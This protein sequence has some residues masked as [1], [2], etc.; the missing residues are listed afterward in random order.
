MALSLILDAA[1]RELD[2][3]GFY[4]YFPTKKMAEVAQPADNT[5][6]KE[7]WRDHSTR[8]L[9]LRPRQYQPDF[10]DT[11]QQLNDGHGSAVI[12]LAQM[13]VYSGNL[14]NNKIF[15]SP[16]GNNS[17]PFIFHEPAGPTTFFP[18]AAN[19]FPGEAPGSPPSLTSVPVPYDTLPSVIEA[20][21]MF[22]STVYDVPTT[23]PTS[24][25]EPA[26]TSIGNT[27]DGKWLCHTAARLEAN[28]GL[29]L[30]WLHTDSRAGFPVTYIFAIGQFC[31]RIKGVEVEVFRDTSTH[32]DRSAWK[33]VLNAPLWSSRSDP[34][35]ATR[36]PWE[37][38]VRVG[39]AI[40]EGLNEAF[41][42]HYCSLLWLP[43]RRHQVLLRSNMGQEA[44]LTVRGTPQRLPDDSDWDITREDTLAIWVMTPAPGHLQV[45][46]LAYST[47]N[48]D[49]LSPTVRLDYSPSGSVA[50]GVVGDN[51]HSTTLSSTLSSP[52]SYTLTED[53]TDTCVTA[54][55]DDDQS[56]TYGVKLRLKSSDGRHTPFFYGLSLSAERTF[57]TRP[58]T[59]FTVGSVSSATYHL[60]SAELSCGLNPGEGRLTV[61]LTDASPYTLAPYYYRSTM[62]VQLKSGSTVI[63]TGWTEPT[64]VTPLKETGTPWQLTISAHDRWKQLTEVILQDVRDF[65]QFGHIDA[66]VAVMQQAGIDTTDIITPT[67]TPNV[68]SAMNTMLGLGEPTINQK[69][70]TVPEAWK[71]KDQETAAMFIKR[72]AELFSGWDVGFHLDGKPFYHPRDFYTTPTATF[73]TAHSSSSPY[74]RHVNFRPESPEANVIVVWTKKADNGQM[75]RS[76]EFVDWASIKNKNVVNYMGKRRPEAIEIGHGYSCRMLNWAARKIWDQTRRRHI[77]AEFEA[78]FVET[79]QVGHVVTIGSYGDY[80]L[81]N[82]NVEMT[83]GTMTTAHYTGEKLEKG[84]GLPA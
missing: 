29:Y 59:P 55:G 33:K 49:V 19:P 57:T 35:T 65:S 56:R 30:R 6:A 51:D 45:Q 75:M 16:L 77:V 74:C 69:T 14:T 1:L 47:A 78:D 71:P 52:P 66:V 11:E 21:S 5:S 2:E 64:E 25:S 9:M 13:Q 61:K 23:M 58:T 44:V 37:A 24:G 10:R 40:G 20:P 22:R 53:D 12:R 43:Y 36:N 34:P 72:I 32:G 70:A 38:A 31:L 63:F 67:Y 42:N 73:A 60:D 68:I 83:H 4:R 50:V 82:I 28:Q 17:N 76:S 39:F 27:A 81:T 8:T 3:P 15:E 48:V 84:F 7:L 46:K 79:L 54:T 41:L 18:A 80:R 26:A 62:P